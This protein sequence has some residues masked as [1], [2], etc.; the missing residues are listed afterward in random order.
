MNDYKELNYLISKSS[1]QLLA[2]LASTFVGTMEINNKSEEFM[3][4]TLS[5][6]FIEF[7]NKRMNRKYN[8][9]KYKKSLESTYEI[10]KKLKKEK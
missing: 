8:P 5:K 3:K 9:K 10:Y 6:M 4:N 2:F 1:T 7:K